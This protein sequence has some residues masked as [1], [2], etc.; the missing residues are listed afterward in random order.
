MER[1]V[2]IFFHLSDLHIGKQLHHYSLI[3]VQRELLHQI[4]EHVRKER[5]DV[6]L[7]A[8]DVYDT[9]IPSAE[10]IMVFND[11]LS[12]LDLLEQELTICIIAGNHDS[13]R[14]LDYASQILKKHKIYIVGMPPMTEEEYI[15]TVS[16]KDKFGEVVFYLLPFVKP[17][18][19]KKLFFE[20]TLSYSDAIM[21]LLKR[22]QIDQTKRNVLVSHQFYAGGGKEPIRSNSELH[23]AGGI[24]N[25]SIEALKSFDYAALGHI[26]RSQ[27][28]GE[29]KNWYCG[30][31][32]PYSVSEVEEEYIYCQTMKES[33]TVVDC[34]FS[35]RTFMQKSMSDCNE[36]F[37]TMVELGEKGS[38]PIR[39]KLFLQMPK[40]VRKIRGTLEEVLKLAGEDICDD[41]VSI[42]LTDE[43]EASHSR[44]ILEDRYDHILEIKI[45]NAR[46]RKLLELREAETQQ[47]TPYEAF[48]Q[49]FE[50]LNGRRMTEEEDLMLKEILEENEV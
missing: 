29:E 19:V 21:R 32:F 26:H 42:T 47:L 43:I 1:G 28:I 23:T 34:C 22:E 35:E 44:E 33:D 50:E 5:P 6:L 41:Y 27:K 2:M 14:R 8:G 40:K 16:I 46:T 45:D 4:V 7:V 20:E 10:A 24:D 48:G 39:K 11:F 9:S 30:T 31:I 15:Q 25:V 37:I 12:E 17:I 3:E 38:Q 36:K 13:G 18:F 49:F